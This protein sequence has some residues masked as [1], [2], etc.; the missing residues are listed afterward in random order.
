[1]KITVS[2][3]HEGTLLP[4]VTIASLL[5][6]DHKWENGEVEWK[7]GSPG[8]PPAFKGILTVEECEK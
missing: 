3:E 4:L 8:E 7:C 2:V 5:N 6:K 1:M